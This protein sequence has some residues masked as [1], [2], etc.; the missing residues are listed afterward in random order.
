MST[1]SDKTPEKSKHSAS[2]VVCQKHHLRESSVHITDNRPDSVKQRDLQSVVN[3]S[4]QVNQLKAIQN[5]V[6]NS[7]QRETKKTPDTERVSKTIQLKDALSRG[8]QTDTIQRYSVGVNN[9]NGK[10]YNVSLGRE[11]I[12]GIDYPNH[13]LYVRNPSILATLNSSVAQGFLTFS[14]K[15]TVPFSWQDEEPVNYY[16]VYPEYKPEKKI[17]D[18]NSKAIGQIYR[19][20]KD[21]ARENGELVLPTDDDHVVNNIHKNNETLRKILVQ[22]VYNYGHNKDITL[23]KEE[24]VPVY[25]H[26]ND[27][28]DGE[29]DKAS[30]LEGLGYYRGYIDSVIPG[31][32]DSKSTLLDQLKNRTDLLI[33]QLGNID[34]C[35]KF[36]RKLA[37]LRDQEISAY[38]TSDNLLLPR[39]CDLVS[40]T[41]MGNKTDKDSDT[42]VQNL[43]F[44]VKKDGTH[45][46][47]TKILADGI[48]FITIEGFAKSGYTFFD[49]T[50]EFIMHGSHSDMETSFN[51]YTKTR[52]SFFKKFG[53][54]PIDSN[55]MKNI[56]LSN[57]SI[58]AT[59][60]HTLL[61]K[62]A[63]VI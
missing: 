3:S 25:N 46:Y 42:Q 51:E 4:R 23:L 56:G 21:E 41:V 8:G 37:Y 49:N 31:V 7:L 34:S 43:N 44:N 2:R 14:N 40:G 20:V 63:G 9:Q 1:H 24:Y 18:H 39:G 55:T 11:L 28:L 35:N 17:K 16:R 59:G 54:T 19:E 58:L 60:M 57:N 27:F 12:C 33:Q 38:N 32:F 62:K 47:A 13:E 30:A 61:N 36:K 26:I 22:W 45:H 6:N 5:S 29:G 15:G 10:L 52:Y 50:W 53:N 48:D